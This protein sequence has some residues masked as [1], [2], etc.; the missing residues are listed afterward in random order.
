VE[1]GTTMGNLGHL[2][3]LAVLV[4]LLY[5]ILPQKAYAYL[6]PGTG[7]YMFQLAIALLAGGFFAI[8]LYWRRIKTFFGS[9][10]SKRKN[11]GKN[12]D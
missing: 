12:S 6:D 2:I 9:V 5:L 3:S 1:G 4:A 7:S 11:G 8:K 10:L